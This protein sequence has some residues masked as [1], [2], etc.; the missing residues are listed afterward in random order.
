MIDLEAEYLAALGDT[1]PLRRRQ[2]HQAGV[3][4][5]AID[6]AGPAYT[7][8]RPVGSALF[9]PNPDSN[10]G[11]FILPVR[12]DYPDTPESPD[13]EAVIEG[14]D[15]VDLVAFDPEVGAQ[16]ILRA[17]NAEWLGACPPQYLDPPPVPLHRSPIDWLRAGCEGVVCLARA[18]IEIHRFLCRFAALDVAD[19]RHAE[20]LQALLERPPT[21]PEILVG[22]RTHR[23][24]G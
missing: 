3:P 17:G 23:H 16:W 9:E 18:P 5:R 24:V 13:P 6:L 21:H 14:G 20:E 1:S 22:G 19:D 2:L 8:V 4:Q 10:L 15:I 12:V 7:R 11:A